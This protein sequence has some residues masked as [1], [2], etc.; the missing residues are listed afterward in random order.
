MLFAGCGV[1][2]QLAATAKS[3]KTAVSA[4]ARVVFVVGMLLALAQFQGRRADP[5][6]PPH[7]A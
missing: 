1:P 6:G 4:T 5:G 7:H 3:R 2:T